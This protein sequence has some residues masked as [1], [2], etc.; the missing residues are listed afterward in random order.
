MNI[1]TDSVLFL[2]LFILPGALSKILLHEF[3][4]KRDAN[5]DK[6]T[7]METAEI[8]VFSSIVL[9]FN[10]LI[11]T[12]FRTNKNGADIL[13]SIHSYQFLIKY[14]AL[15]ICITILFTAILHFVV[16]KLSNKGTNIYNKKNGK[17]EELPFPTVWENIFESNK[18]IDITK[19]DHIVSIEKGGIIVSCGFLKY[20]PAPQTNCNELGL[21]RSKEVEAFFARDKLCTKDEY[22]VFHD[23][24]LEYY[25]MEYDVVIKFYDMQKYIEV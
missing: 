3:A 11:V 18:I 17:C 4:P 5:K 14:I 13:T 6:T 2:F 22:K 21:I 23:T 12:F 1:N 10:S 16:K 19:G 15:T 7:I 8:I 24:I 9:F 20:F 25:N